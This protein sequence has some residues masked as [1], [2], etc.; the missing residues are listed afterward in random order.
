MKKLQSYTESNNK[1]ESSG[2]PNSAWDLSGRQ[3]VTSTYIILFISFNQFFFIVA[4]M[5][6]NHDDNAFDKNAT[7]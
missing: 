6:T 1:L 4:H 5:K 3:F 7:L 2:S